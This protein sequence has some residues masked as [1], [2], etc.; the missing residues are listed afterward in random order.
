[1]KREDKLSF[2]KVV[3]DKGV[4]FINGAID[5]T[6]DTLKLSKQTI[7]TILMKLEYNHKEQKGNSKYY[8]G[9]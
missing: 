6:S 9:H 7:Y 1:M 8:R 3:D 4:F 2:I 5:Q